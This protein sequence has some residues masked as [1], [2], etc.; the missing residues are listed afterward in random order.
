MV[1]LPCNNYLNLDKEKSLGKKLG[2]EP[3]PNII[4]K[5]ERG[6]IQVPELQR[7][8]VWKRPQVELL[9]DSIYRGCPIG[10]LTLYQPPAEMGGREGIYWVLDGQ[11]RLFSLQIITKGSV[12]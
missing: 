1:F 4:A 12:K 9:V 6:D 10:M 11:Q 2:E 3:I 8:F 7:V 5:L